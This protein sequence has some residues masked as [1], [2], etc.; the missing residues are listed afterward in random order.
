M[1]L[2]VRFW[3]GDSD[4]VQSRYFGSSF[5]GHTRHLDLLTHF[6]DLTKDLNPSKLFEISVDGPNTNLKFFNE[7]S[8]KFAETTLPSLI[9]I[10][11]CNIHIVYGCLQTGESLSGWG[12]KNMKSAYRILRNS[13]VRRE[14]Y[15]TVTA[16]SIYSFNFCATRYNLLQTIYCFTNL[17]DLRLH[18]NFWM[19]E[20]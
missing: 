10:A 19:K 18:H 2:Y 7:Y 4:Q 8:N 20:T 14:D 9:N 12:L 11:T 3:N 6:R 1:D 16:S 13:P 17:L 15:V 5:L